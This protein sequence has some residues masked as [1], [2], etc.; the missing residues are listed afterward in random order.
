MS[1]PEELQA[2]AGLRRDGALTE[3]EFAQAKAEVIAKYGGT[4]ADEPGGG[5]AELPRT[6]QLR[7]GWPHRMGTYELDGYHDGKARYRNKSFQPQ[8][9]HIIAWSSMHGR[10]QIATFENGDSPLYV[11]GSTNQASPLL[12]PS[13]GW[14]IHDNW[15][16]RKWGAW[17]DAGH[18][19][20]EF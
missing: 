6:V 9:W 4:V 18:L 5:A 1:L 3:Q 20:L 15:N 17:R 14:G 11:N 7:G 19:L 13:E 10:W 8:T 16:T 2:L 12:P